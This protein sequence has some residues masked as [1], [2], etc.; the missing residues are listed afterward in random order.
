MVGVFILAVS[1]S[2]MNI[3]ADYDSSINFSTYKTFAW[4]KSSTQILHANE[5]A[6]I[7]SI[8]NDIAV[9][10]TKELMG[11]GYIMDTVSPDIVISCK[12]TGK[13]ETRGLGQLFD[14]V[15]NTKAPNWT[16]LDLKSKEGTLTITIVDSMKQRIIWQ[17]NAEGSV[18]D[19]L[20]DKN[21]LPKSIKSIFNNYPTFSSHHQIRANNYFNTDAPKLERQN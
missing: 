7:P 20:S 5:P 18:N 12:I 10:T 9:C 2:K 16:P 19:V 13:N 14:G 17:A 21:K 4:D 1:C 6:G 3:Y 11:R 15:W 8:E